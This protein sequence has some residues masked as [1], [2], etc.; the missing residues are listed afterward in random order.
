MARSNKHHAYKREALIQI[1]LE[2]FL[3]NGYENT[4]ITQIMKA[5][6]LSKGGMYHYFSSKE[7]ILDAVIQHGLLQ[8]LEKTK[9]GLEIL[10]VE[11]KL[12]YFTTSSD[13]ISSFTQKL[14]AYKDNNSDSIVAY[15]IREY[16]VHLCTPILADIIEQG[17]VAGIYKTPYPK[18]M[19][20]FFVLLVKAVVETNFLPPANDKER[21]RRMEAFV[22]LAG[23]CL[24]LDADAVEKMRQLLLGELLLQPIKEEP[25]K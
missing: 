20:E 21:L 9:A 2:L 7:E 18:E 17:V 1:A 24:G 13:S 11:E 5:A 8:E 23:G 19:G 4:T 3:E 15:R 14:L 25:T 6:E 12:A 22:H 16:N 10:P